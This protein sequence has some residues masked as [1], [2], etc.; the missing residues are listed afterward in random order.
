VNQRHSKEKS[1][2]TR[3]RISLGLACAIAVLAGLASSA[4]ARVADNGPARYC[5]PN[6]SRVFRLW[7][8]FAYY[9]LSPGGSFEA[10]AAEW[11]L[12]GGASVVHGNEPFYL[13]SQQD[14]QSLSMPAGS[15]ATSP[16]MC[17]STGNWHFRFVGRGDGRVRVTVRV[18]GLLGVIS[19]LDGGTVWM[20]GSWHP[21]PRVS[22]LLTNVGGLLTTKAISLHFTTVTG[23]AQIDDVYVDPWVST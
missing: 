5:D 4:D 22:L 11:A 8:D 3:L 14:R 20:N 23:T 21:S 6:S 12:S 15:S 1:V 18:R 13:R 17:F 16:W 19:I 10:G 2:A 9:M 7:N